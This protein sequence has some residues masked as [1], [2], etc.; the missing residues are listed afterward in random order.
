MARMCYDR[1]QQRPLVPM[2]PNGGAAHLTPL[3]EMGASLY[4]MVGSMVRATIET[5]HYQMRRPMERPLHRPRHL[6]VGSA[7]S[8]LLR[9]RALPHGRLERILSAVRAYQMVRLGRVPGP[10]DGRGDTEVSRIYFVAVALEELGILRAGSL[11]RVME[12]ARLVGTGRA[13]QIR[14]EDPAETMLLRSPQSAATA[15]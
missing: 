11:V 4:G 7:L 8:H 2:R 13:H 14:Q 3:Q 6:G 15:L 9:H 5:L 1:H 12:M 10:G